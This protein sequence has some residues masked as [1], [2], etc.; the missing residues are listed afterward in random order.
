MR[1][2]AGSCPSFEEMEEV[3]LHA[4]GPHGYQATWAVLARLVHPQHLL[5][6]TCQSALVSEAGVGVG[7]SLVADMTGDE[8]GT[9]SLH[10]TALSSSALTE[11]EAPGMGSRIHC[12]P[13]STLQ[14]TPNFS[15]AKHSQ[16]SFQ[17]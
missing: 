6:P 10:V 1:V 7:Q 5:A 9:Q 12:G 17:E 4:L 8:L 16:A 14:I 15:A 13:C 3:D 2:L 11:R